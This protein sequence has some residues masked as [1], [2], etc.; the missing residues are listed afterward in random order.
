MVALRPISY[1]VY[2]RS[3]QFTLPEY[4]AQVEADTVY[5]IERIHSKQQLEQ[6]PQP[7]DR[8]RYRLTERVDL[9]H[10]RIWRFDRASGEHVALLTDWD[11]S[12]NGWTFGPSGELYFQAEDDG[13]AR[14]YRFRGG[15]I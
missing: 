1:Y 6:L 15:W 8:Q 11:R 2:R 12:P 7:F 10:S 4:T 3:G 13:C 14:L 9:P 5:V